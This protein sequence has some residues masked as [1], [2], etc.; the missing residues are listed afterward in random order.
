MILLN[1]TLV[2][3]SRKEAFNLLQGALQEAQDS[4]K[5]SMVITEGEL[6]SLYKFFAPS[7]TKKATT[8]FQQVAKAVDTKDVR[9][10]FHYVHSTG[11]EICATNGHMLLWAESDLPAGYYD[12][13]TG[14]L[15][16]Y[17][18]DHYPDL[19]KIRGQVEG[20]EMRCYT[21]SELKQVAVKDVQCYV[22][23][24]HRFQTKYI[25]KMTNGRPVLWAGLKGDMG[26]TQVYVGDEAV[27]GIVMRCNL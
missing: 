4:P 24:D 21:V 15:T 23:G 22:I 17:S 26:K 27:N 18:S 12:P 3:P 6:Q 25:D 16:D 20:A 14:D 11:T 5:K 13:K 10:Y 8:A 1:T 7:L 19:D 2:K 9:P